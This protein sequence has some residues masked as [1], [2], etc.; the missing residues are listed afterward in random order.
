MTIAAR[1]VGRHSKPDVPARPSLYDPEDLLGVV[2]PDIRL[3]MDMME[4]ILRLVDD[5]RLELFKP[6]WGKAMITTWAY[7]HGMAEDF[8]TAFEPLYRI[9]ANTGLS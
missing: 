5:S 8:V 1:Q 3:P 2:N 4:I 9:D 6:L 7:I